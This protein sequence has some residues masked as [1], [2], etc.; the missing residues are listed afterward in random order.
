MTGRQLLG[1]TLG[2]IVTGATISAICDVGMRRGKLRIVGTVVAYDLPVSGLARL[3][4][5]P[6]EQFLIVRI[7]KP[8][9]RKPELTYIKVS[10]RRWFNE[11]E[12]P[13]GILEGKNKWRFA[14]DARHQ[15]RWFDA[16]NA[17]C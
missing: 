7:D 13:S 3:T 12:L 4:S 6:M 15:L 5:V 1:L 9:H 17:I 16:R 8:I 14:A 2:I 11:P 10:Y